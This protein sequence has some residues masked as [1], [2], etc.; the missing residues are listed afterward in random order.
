MVDA[1]W[2]VSIGN[3][4]RIT[5][6]FEV[7]SK[8]NIDSMLLNLLK[9]RNNPSVQG[10]VAVSD[11]AQIEKIKKEAATLNGLNDLKYWDYNDV[12]KVYEHLSEAFGSIN[13]LGLVPNGLF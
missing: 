2:E 7:Q 9:S 12:I 13:S 10:V 11:A 5:Y 6:V 1:I 4:G 3:M 8:G